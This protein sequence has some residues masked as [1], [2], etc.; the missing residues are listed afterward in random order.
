MF[1]N[2]SI[3]KIIIF[4]F[5]VIM[6][7]AVYRILTAD[8]KMTLIPHITA[9]NFLYQMRFEFIPGIGYR[10]AGGLFII[11][12]SCIGARLFICLFL[13]LSICRIDNYEGFLKKIGRIL[14]FCITAVFL[15]YIITVFRITAS[16]PFCRLENFQLIHTIF[17]LMVYFASGIG[18]YAFLSYKSEKKIINKEE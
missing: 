18:L 17:S 11:G 7:F 10:E 2:F 3:E 4:L 16:I 6:A 12:Q 1:K 13:I 9:V 14:L 5:T 15:A 8:I